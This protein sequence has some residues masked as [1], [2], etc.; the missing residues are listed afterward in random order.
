MNAFCM[1]EGHEWEGGRKGKDAI[2]G[3]LSPQNSYSEALDF[4]CDGI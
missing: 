3:T 1:Q 2:E 4:Q